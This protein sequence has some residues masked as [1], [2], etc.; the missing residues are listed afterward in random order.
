MSGDKAVDGQRTLSENIAD[1]GGLHESHRAYVN[2]VEQLGA[3]PRL[4]GLTQFTPEQL[5]FVS[6]AQV[7]LE[8]LDMTT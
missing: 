8:K 2:S 5:F 3:E 4:P 6:F 1:N 7:R